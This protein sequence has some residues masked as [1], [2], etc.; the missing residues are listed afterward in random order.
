[1]ATI[2]GSGVCAARSW[3]LRRLGYEC[4]LDLEASQARLQRLTK[5]LV[6][7]NQALLLVTRDME[8]VLEAE[9][10]RIARDIH[11]EL[12]S[13]LTALQLELAGASDPRGQRKRRAGA[14]LVDDAVHA[15]Q[16]VS[17]G[18]KPKA[19]DHQ[20]L[21]QAV[22][23]RAQ[24]FGRQARMPCQ[25]DIPDDL[26]EPPEVVAMTVYRVF[27]EALT[28]VARHAHA[29]AVR[30]HAELSS[31]SLMLEVIDN[32]RGIARDQLDRPSALGLANMRARARAVGGQVYVGRGE[33]GGTVARLL[34]PRSILH[35]A[36]A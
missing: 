18:L 20:G 21:W 15:V 23:A 27:D 24:N 36:A 33:R 17:M 9:R 31:D 3:V 11:D 30:V 19:L 14:D 2:L 25:I 29:T 12:G 22:D 4:Q 34:L 35:A 26:P 7:A 5:E 8:D 13:T 32:G 28:N 6:R 10:M 16:R 1:M